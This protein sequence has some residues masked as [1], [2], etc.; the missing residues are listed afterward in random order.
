MSETS[1]GRFLGPKADARMGM[2]F[3]PGKESLFNGTSNI[4]CPRGH[5]EEEFGLGK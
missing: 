5:G 3:A 4:Y 1:E 2:V